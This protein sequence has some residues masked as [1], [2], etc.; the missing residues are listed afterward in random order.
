MIVS[1]RPNGGVGGGI[2]SAL[3]GYMNGLDDI[4]VPYQ[5]VESHVE[6]KSILVSWWLAFWQIVNIA[7]KC[8]GDVVFWYHCGPWLSLIRKFSL[9]LVPRLL[10][11]KTVAHIHSPTFN[12]YLS[13]SYLSKILTKLS[14][15][16]YQELIVLTPWWK[17][18]LLNAGINKNIT[19]SPNPNSQYFC[20][21]ARMK[22]TSNK[23]Y[24]DDKALVHI[25]SMARLIEGKGIEL[26]IKAVA[27]LPENFILTIAGEGPQKSYYESIVN[28][29]KLSN[30]VTFCGWIDGERK[31]RLL[32]QSDI[33][34]LPSS[35]DSFGMVFIEA[36]A[37]N[38]PVIAY[39]WGPIQDVVTDDVGIC[40][41]KADEQEIAANILQIHSQLERYEGK[42]P[43]K[44][45]K[46]YTPKVVTKNI[47]KLIK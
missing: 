43:E 8:R 13:R 32:R 25:I 10:G 1:T 22:V 6:G 27:L 11:C 35:Y 17:K 44:V 42:G 46:Y 40:C 23:N 28:E 3:I 24:K 19:I 7:I 20:D 45:L 30:R 41:L 9:A 14:L 39:G 12:G 16:P 33:F 2:P 15:T 29:L 47:I 18:L 5:V 38:L 26:V 4:A 21:I 34:C 37:F 31:E 36:M